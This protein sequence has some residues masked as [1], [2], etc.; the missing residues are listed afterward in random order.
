MGIFDEERGLTGRARSQRTRDHA[1]PAPTVQPIFTPPAATP[2]SY[3][4]SAADY[5]LPAL[6]IA[7]LLHPRSREKIGQGLEYALPKS[8]EAIDAKAAKPLQHMFAPT[9]FSDYGVNAAPI[10]AAT[11]AASKGK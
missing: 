4:N 1:R 10:D 2:R 3:L 5:A 7:A 11:L 8:T 9:S 6:G